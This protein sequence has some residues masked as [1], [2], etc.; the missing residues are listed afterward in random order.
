[1]LEREVV[2]VG[3]D[4]GN[5]VPSGSRQK[6]GSIV[7]AVFS[8]YQNDGIAYIQKYKKGKKGHEES[9]EWI[10]EG[11]YF[12]F[13]ILRDT[14]TLVRSSNI[15][16]IAP[17]LIGDFLQSHPYVKKVC[18]YIDGEMHPKEEFYMKASLPNLERN[19][20]I[21]SYPKISIRDT[22]SEKN[23]KDDKKKKRKKKFYH[24]PPL[25][26]HADVLAYHLC[27]FIGP[28]GDKLDRLTTDD[29]IRRSFKRRF[30][31]IAKM[32]EIPIELVRQVG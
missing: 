9:R 29:H 3:I 20:L 30:G 22:E 12:S 10:K 21:E 5:Y 17:Y 24:S 19:F 27:R 7:A 6:K 28:L 32:V 8:F 18:L 2:H 16:I 15:H 11:R 25:I 31:G 23:E 13:A 26:R 4:E 1:M 14:A